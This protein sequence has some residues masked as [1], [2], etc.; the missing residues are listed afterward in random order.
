M[1]QA[2]VWIPAFAGMTSV[3]AGMTVLRVTPQSIAR[4][5]PG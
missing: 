5:S 3:F 2:A 4:L 1:S